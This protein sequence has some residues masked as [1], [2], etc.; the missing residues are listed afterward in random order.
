MTGLRLRAALRGLDARLVAPGPPARL[1]A[2]QV[3][4]AVVLG[5]RLATRDWTVVA[6]RPAVLTDRVSMLG[7]MPAPVPVWLLV[8]LQVTGLVGVVLVLVR[9]APRVGFAT[10][11]AALT[12][13]AGTAGMSGKVMHNDILLVTVGA[14]LVVA[15]TPRRG[16]GRAAPTVA[17]GWPPRAALA[18][19]GTVY[20][21]TGAQKLRHS[22]LEWV[23]GDNM[24]WVLRQGTSPFGAG[25]TQ[26]VADHAL[27]PHALAAGALALEL[28]APVLLAVRRTRALFA[29]TAAVMHTSIW[30]FLGLDYS[31]WVLTV[32]AVAVP[33]AVPARWWRARS[34]VPP[35]S[36]EHVADLE[37]AGTTTS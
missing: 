32:A 20:F 35:P 26:A 5:L 15:G 18:V 19:I 36:A 1:V 27:L 21:L 11:W 13:L 17:A 30:A 16:D 14:V 33:M 10:A 23:L 34:P 12:V 6:Q 24:A 37:A 22:G 3:A 25:L 29:L 9:R 4:L 8:A 31:A 28:A 7:W 2:I